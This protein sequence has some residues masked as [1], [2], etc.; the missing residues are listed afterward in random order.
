MRRVTLDRYRVR[1][2]EDVQAT[3]VVTPYRGPDLVLTR[4]INIPS[5]TPPGRLN[6]HVGSA[7]AVSR[8]EGDDPPV[9][10]RDLDQLIWLINN[11]RR[12]D[13]VYIVALQ[14]D[15]GVYLGGTRLP[16]LPPSVTSVL[17]RPRTLGNF[18]VIPE[19]GVFEESILTDYM[20][21]GLAKVHLEVETP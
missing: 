4:E 3:V 5:E 15:S 19:R 10:P 2:G 1:A 12:N 6:L 11:L 18:A 9:F 17:S 21:Q 13:R 16:N 7:L 20:V 8:S 14:E